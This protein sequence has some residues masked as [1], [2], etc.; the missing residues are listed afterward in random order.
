MS[1]KKVFYDQEVQC[2]RCFEDMIR[3]VESRMGKS[4]E[5]DICPKCRGLWLDSGELHKM[6]KDKK[7]SDYLTK[8]IGTKSESK[9]VCP[10][11]GGLM[12]LEFA[13]EIEVDVCINCNGVFL[14][15]GELNDLKIKSKEGFA[16][17]P[18]EK[19][20]ER[21][22]NDVEKNRKSKFNQFFKRIGL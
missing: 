22:E 19:A 16:G 20:V 3:A 4:F 6:L 9:L 17:D 13:D 15:E 14:D 2:P 18:L 5:I 8:D 7:L 1:L 21:W 11:C 10:R 12:D